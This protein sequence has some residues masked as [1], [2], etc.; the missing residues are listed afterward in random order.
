MLGIDLIDRSNLSKY[1][2][3]FK[4]IF[5]IVDNYKYSRAIPLKDQSGK[6]TTTAFKKLIETSTRKTPKKCGRIEKKVFYNETFLDFLKQNEQIY[7]THSH[8]KAV[9]VER[10]NRTMLDLIKEPMYIKVKLVG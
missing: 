1:N 4:L 3:N 9:F 8:L 7:S 2:K 6:S 5:T 10:F